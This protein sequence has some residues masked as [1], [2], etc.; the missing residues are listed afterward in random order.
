MRANLVALGYGNE[1]LVVSDPA[2]RAVT[3]CCV[4]ALQTRSRLE[5]SLPASQ[6]NRPRHVSYA[7]VC[8]GNCRATGEDGRVRSARG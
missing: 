6:R 8:R 3:A 4:D 1:P 2:D 5:I 7:L